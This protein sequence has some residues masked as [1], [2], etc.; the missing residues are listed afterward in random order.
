MFRSENIHYLTIY[1]VS[2]HFGGP[3]EGGWWYDNYFC[4]YSEPVNPSLIT[5]AQLDKRKG[6]L[7]N[8]FEDLLY[9]YNEITCICESEKRMFEDT[10]K[11]YYS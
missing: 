10:S 5:S 8:K 9:N 6:E 4:I 11:P 7:E 1:G 3:E 2:R